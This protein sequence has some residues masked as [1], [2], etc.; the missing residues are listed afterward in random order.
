M[1]WN[2]CRVRV[3]GPKMS[4]V[5]EPNTVA[6]RHHPLRVESCIRFS[7]I[8]SGHR[9]AT[10]L[11]LFYGINKSCLGAATLHG[12]SG[13]R[14]CDLA[15]DPSMASVSPEGLGMKDGSLSLNWPQQ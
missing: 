15:S 6:K 14:D 2:G 3:A 10:N 1:H 13:E 11:Q 12:T 5:A 9:H 8:T 4:Q 7:G